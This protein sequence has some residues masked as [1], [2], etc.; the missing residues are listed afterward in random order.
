[1][2][3]LVLHEFPRWQPHK[4]EVSVNFSPFDPPEK[5]SGGQNS[6]TSGFSNAEDHILVEHVESTK[7]VINIMRTE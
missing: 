7:D 1:V 3:L 4:K 5:I 2:S 6:T